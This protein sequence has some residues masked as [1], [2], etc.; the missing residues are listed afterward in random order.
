MKH[1]KGRNFPLPICVI[2]GYRSF[3]V[4]CFL[5]KLYSLSDFI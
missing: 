5:N 4:I 3:S 2:S 1:K